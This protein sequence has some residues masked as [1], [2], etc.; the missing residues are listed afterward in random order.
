MRE[1]TTKKKKKGIRLLKHNIG[2]Y[3][4]VKQ[5]HQIFSPNYFQPGITSLA[6]ILITYERIMAFV[7]MQSLANLC[8]LSNAAPPKQRINQENWKTRR[9]KMSTQHRK[10]TNETCKMTV[11]EAIGWQSAAVTVINQ[12]KLEIKNRRC[13]RF[14]TNRIHSVLECTERR[15]IILATNW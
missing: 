5:Y 6:K 8:S 10:M 9:Q 3:K 15:F 7:E 14:Q 1:Q 12:D 11:K 2:S 13:R 4:S